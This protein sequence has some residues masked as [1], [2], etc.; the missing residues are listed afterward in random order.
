M[1]DFILDFFF[2]K[3]CVGCNKVGSYFCPNCVPNI[4]QKDLVCPKC[5]RSSLGGVTHPVCRRKYGLD[6]LWSLG[7]YQDSLQI[8]I[9]K[10]KYR[11]VTEIAQVLSNLTL[12]Y[13]AKNSPLILE[14]IKKDRGEGWTVVP[15]PLHWQRQ[16]WRGFNQSA[17]I[18][19][20]LAQS[21]G[22]EYQEA[23]KRVKNTKPQVQ[24]KADKRRS[25][26]KNA[27]TLNP[28]LLP[29]E[30]NVLLIDDVWTTGS[31][32]QECCYVLKR[33][34]VKSVWALTIAR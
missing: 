24:L 9:Q 33:G 34:G 20:N 16:N 32:L 25:N 26:I 7:A 15:V 31:T 4:L 12:E 13:W 6:G 27:F 10:L 5:E 11:W 28:S 8:G 1:F 2:P 29:L 30:P 21:L 19:K 17:L 18:G 22:L 3:H 14:K 23:L